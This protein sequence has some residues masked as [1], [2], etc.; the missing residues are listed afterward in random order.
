MKSRYLGLFL[1]LIGFA[2]PFVLRIIFPVFLY[3]FVPTTLCFWAGFLMVLRP[4]DG[5]NRLNPHLKWGRYA[6]LLNIIL[7][8]L[9]VGYFYLLFYFDIRRGIGF[10]VMSFLAFLANPVQSVS[11]IFVPKPM[12]QRADGSV[13]VTTTFIRSLFTDFFNLVFY[14]TLGIIVK[15]IKDK[16]I[17]SAFSG[18][19]KN[20]AR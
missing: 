16:K 4:F 13:L 8:T 5:E 11:D 9:L 10:H 20:R 7:T 6:I 12:V 2:F 17:T 19:L 15:V 3:A 18:S 1:I 14:G